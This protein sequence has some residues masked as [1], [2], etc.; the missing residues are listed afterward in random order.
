MTL[1]KAAYIV[2]VFMHLGDERKSLKYM[3]LAPYTI[4]ALYLIFVGITESNFVNEVWQTYG[5]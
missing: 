5:E 3:I 1:V 4:F 2:V